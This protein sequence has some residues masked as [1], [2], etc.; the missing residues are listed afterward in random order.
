MFI[1]AK[2]ARGELQ[3]QG[4]V[5]SHIN[6]FIHYV[7]EADCLGNNN[8]RCVCPELLVSLFSVKLS[9]KQSFVNIC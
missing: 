1:S 3:Q 2:T 8:N 6:M 7:N 4:Y 9:G 5:L